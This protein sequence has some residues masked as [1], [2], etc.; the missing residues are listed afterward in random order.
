MGVREVKMG[1]EVIMG[2]Y[3]RNSKYLQRQ[4]TGANPK[5]SV[6]TFNISDELL[7]MLACGKARGWWCSRSEGI[8]VACARGLAIIADEHETLEQR[9]VESLQS[10]NKLDASKIYVKI[11]GRGYIE[12]LGEA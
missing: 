12:I 10:R 7:D 5:L 2:R 4:R 3:N 6:L 9:V 1:G 8:R 11:P